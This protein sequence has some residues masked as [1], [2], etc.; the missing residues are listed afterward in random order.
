MKIMIAD[1]RTLLREGLKQIINH[2]NLGKVTKEVGNGS[3]CLDVI[4]QDDSFDLL[5]MDADLPD[6]SGYEI[7]KIMKKES[8]L[9]P[10]LLLSEHEN[11]DSIMRAMDVGAGGFLNMSATAAEFCDGILKVSKGYEFVQPE[12]IPLLNSGLIKRDVDS[13]KIASLTRRELEV[14]KYVAGGMFNREIALSLCIS[15]RT[16]KNH[17]SSIFKKIDVADRTQAAVFAIRNNLIQI[18]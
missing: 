14:L 7:V 6:L 5:I 15:E 17:I 8:I 13:D 9:I 2:E 11:L 18:H 1:D 10:V 4:R 12:L 3:D 16:V